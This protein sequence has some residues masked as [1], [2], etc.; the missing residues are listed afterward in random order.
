MPAYGDADTA[1]ILGDTLSVPFTFGAYNGR[2]ILDTQD[3]S[4][5]QADGADVVGL[6]TTF[7]VSPAAVPGI[8]RGSAITVDGVNYKV[9]NLM[10]QADGTLLLYLV[11]P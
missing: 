4:M 3:S 2:G 6:Q 7:L 5:N 9:R 11:G 8:K 1:Y 10:K